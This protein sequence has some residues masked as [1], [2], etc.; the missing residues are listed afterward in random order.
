M[1]SKSKAYVVM[2]LSLIYNVCCTMRTTDLCSTPNDYTNSNSLVHYLSS[3][4]PEYSS[5][6]T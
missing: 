6:D 2:Q 1:N 3:S 4:S 5:L